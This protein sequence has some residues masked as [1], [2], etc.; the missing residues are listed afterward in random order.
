MSRSSSS[1]RSFLKHTAGLGVTFATPA[2]SR[3]QIPLP[4][5][6]PLAGH[7][8]QIGDVVSDA[9]ILWSRSDRPARMLVEWSQSPTFARSTRVRGPY[10]LEVSDYTARL[11]LKDL[12]E[13][14]DIFVKILFEGLERNRPLSEPVLGQFRTAPRRRRDIRFVWGGDTAG[15]GWGI[16]LEWGGMRIYKT[17]LD[18]DPDFFLHSGDTI[19]ADGPITDAVTLPDGTV[20]RN[21]FLDKEPGKRKVAETLDEFRGAYRYNLNDANLRAFNARVPQIWQWDDHEVTNNWS[22]AK[23]VSGDAR[24][25]EKRVPLLIG[26]GTRAF[27][28][29]APLRWHGTDESERV[30]RKIP[31]GK[32]LE[33]FVIDMRS[34]RGPNTANLQA[35]QGPETAFLGKEQLDWLKRELKRSKAVWKVI[36]A[37]MPIGLHVPDGPR[38]EAIA[39]GD[40]GPP[41]GRELEI[42]DLLRFIK[43]NVRNVVWLT[44]D[45]HYCAAHRYDPGKAKFQ[46]FAPFWEFV[47]GPL[48][49]GS[50]GPNRLDDTFGPQ[51]V[52]QKAPPPGQSNLPPT[53]GLQFFGQVDID[54]RSKDM[55]VALR[56]VAGTTVFSQRLTADYCDGFRD[57]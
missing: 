29:Y 49:A 43:R 17:M 30:Y 57:E 22:D 9:A 53:A 11:D 8:L 16:N 2:L 6:R 39:N 3:A 54:P 38:W 10:A 51:V 40:N 4:G 27:L 55:V 42:A 15:Q 7:G 5:D 20:W 13:D 56:D 52:F 37:D 25:T 50:F 34:Y 31:Y 19:Y 12:P 45:V 26:R 23:D 1:R 14:K 28:E 24:Y 47:S 41:L 36:A 32:E 35:S 33:V 18:A 44:A 48:N 46:D 21:A